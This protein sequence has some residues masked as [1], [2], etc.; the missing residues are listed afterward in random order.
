MN[1]DRTPKHDSTPPSEQIKDN[2]AS[3]DNHAD[4]CAGP[5]QPTVTTTVTPPPTTTRKPYTPPSTP[6]TT[7]NH[8]WISDAEIHNEVIDAFN[9]VNSY[10]QDL[11]ATWHDKQ[12]EPI[13]WYVPMLYQSDGFYDFDAQPER[14]VVSR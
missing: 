5:E 9:S 13:S 8:Q 6:E 4:T 14:T 12:S 11:F 2:P 1:N 3:G 10:W 7:V